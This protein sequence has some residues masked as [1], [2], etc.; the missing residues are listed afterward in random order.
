MKREELSNYVKGA[1]YGFAI[2]D[3]LGAPLE[4]MSST[5]IA[6][7]YGSVSTYIGGGSCNWEPGEC[8][9][10][11]DMMLA[12]I[13]AY[14][15]SQDIEEFQTKCL[16]KYHNWLDSKPKDVGVQTLQAL[17]HTQSRLYNVAALHDLSSYDWKQAMGNGS[18]MRSLGLCLVHDAKANE[19][20]SMLTHS[21]DC[22]EHLLQYYNFFDIVEDYAT[23]SDIKT[24]RLKKLKEQVALHSYRY[25]SVNFITNGGFVQDTMCSVNKGIEQGLSQMNIMD[26]IIC[27]INNGNDAD[28][29]GALVGGVLGWYMGYNEIP[30]YYIANLL[31]KYQEEINKK[32]ELLVD[33]I[34]KRSII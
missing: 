27:T 26:G 4:F 15:E 31:P 8:T 24:K 16:K 13:E 22:N 28:T 25:K 10:D 34:L 32:A 6:D 21:I 7:N 1:L 9:D 33:I 2:G 19:A 29:V 3:A 30:D 5:A 18:L 20:Q 11:T 23:T 12:T 17:N 14:S